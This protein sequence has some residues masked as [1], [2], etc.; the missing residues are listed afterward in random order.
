[1][2]GLAGWRCLHC[3]V[4]IG[5]PEGRRGQW[6]WEVMILSPARD[7][8]GEYRCAFLLCTASKESIALLD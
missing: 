3:R 8:P 1:M 5:L 2:E 6:I 4:K 7:V